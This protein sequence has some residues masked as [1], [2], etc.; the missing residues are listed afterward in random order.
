MFNEKG[1]EVFFT[2]GEGPG[3][4]GEPDHIEKAHEEAVSSLKREWGP[5]YEGIVESAQYALSKIDGG[6]KIAEIL[7]RTGL[8]DDVEMIS[9]LADAGERLRAGGD[10][11]V[12]ASEFIAALQEDL[13][14]PL[15]VLLK[16]GGPSKSEALAALEEIEATPDHHYHTSRDGDPVFRMVTRLYSIAYE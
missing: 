16:P 11:G 14:G 4:T 3:A 2:V 1:E 12:K 7:D 10:P 8:G 9:H 6:G 5:G 13:E 15:A